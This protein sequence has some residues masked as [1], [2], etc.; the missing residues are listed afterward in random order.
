[1]NRRSAGVEDQESVCEDWTMPDPGLW[2][3]A[4]AVEGRE[5]VA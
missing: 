5:G 4:C 2:R 1:M 3:R